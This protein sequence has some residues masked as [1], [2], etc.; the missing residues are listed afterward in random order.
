MRVLIAP[1][2]YKE[3]LDAVDVAA[4][5]GVGVARAMPDAEIVELPL[6][7]GGEGTAAALARVSGG[8]M[9][10]LT[11]TGPVGDPVEAS[12]AM[13]GGAGP[14]T[15]VVELAQAAGLKHVPRDRRDPLATSSTGVGEL[16]CAA[17]DAGA[18]RIVVGC[19]DSGV[20]DG[21]SGMAAALGIRLLDRAGNP[22]RPGG[23]GLADL[24]TIDLSERDPRLAETEIEVAC[25]MSNLLTGP[26][27][28]ARIY[29]P[30]KGA[31]PEDVERLAAALD[32]YAGVIEQATGRDV[33]LIPG[34]GASGGVGAGLF[35]L[36]G[37]KLRSRFD[38]LLAQS[39]LDAQLATADLV[40]TAEGGLDFKSVRGKIPAEVARRAKLLGIPV[41]VL[42]GTIGEQ[43]ELV[44]EAG[45]DAY[46]STVALPETLEEAIGNAIFELQ[47]TA[48][49]VMHTILAG[50]TLARR[51]A[52]HG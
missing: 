30:Q 29:G 39:G 43:A 13:L 25:N 40:I 20:N 9:H 31:S 52:A 38:V 10:S 28:V 7:D 42:T 21:G 48:E 5:I 6:V 2:G 22:I 3:C 46:F 47:L 1:S 37:A 50:M 49:N 24:A 51:A 12:W 26:D 32:N 35:A 15:A 17:L 27:G 33:R 16:L 4:A 14:A 8:T 23:I 18:R 36:L 41:I 11:V 44:R 45:V 19:G 34:G